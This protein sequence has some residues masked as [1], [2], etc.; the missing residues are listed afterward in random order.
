M[1]ALNHQFSPDP[2]GND[3]FSH[4][5][6]NLGL[7]LVGNFDPPVADSASAQATAVAPQNT[8]TVIAAPAGIVESQT[9]STGSVAVNL[10][11]TAPDNEGEGA[12]DDS[13]GNLI[14]DNEVSQNQVGKD[15]SASDDNSET[16]IST[17]N[18]ELT[19]DDSG[20]NT[21]NESANQKID[22]ELALDFDLLADAA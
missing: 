17:D 21:N 2:L 18:D 15:I 22:G 4:F 12:D 3:L 1:N 9:E 19:T 6:S 20:D 8:S 13:S 16:A 7:P 14:G 11:F 10:S 5:G